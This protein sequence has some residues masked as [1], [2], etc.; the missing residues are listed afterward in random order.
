MTST[1]APTHEELVRRAAALRPLLEKHAA[2]SDENRRL[3]EE[4]VEALADA[5][6][7][8]MRVPAR[9]G[10]YESTART[11]VDVGAEL[12]RG[13][14]AVGWT[15]AIWTI[16]L[17]MAGLFPD[18]VQDEVFATP[19]VRVCGTLSPTAT[20]T[21]AKGGF[22]VDG[23]WSFVSGALHSHW[24]EILAMAPTPDGG[25]QPVM[26]LVP[27]SELEIVDDWH[28]GGLRGT[29]S[30][31]T[32][33]D[34][35]FVPQERVLPMGDV[36]QGK[37][38]SK[39]NADSPM[40]RAPLAATAGASTVGPALGMARAA[41]DVFVKRMPGRP[42]TS[43]GYQDQREAPVT[44]LQ[45]AEAAVRIDEA[46][47]HGYRLADQLDA[48]GV[49]GEPWTIA[50]R[51]RGR[52][53]VAALCRLAKESVDLLSLASG[54]SSAYESVPMQRITRNIQVMNLHALIYPPNAFELYGRVLSGLEPNTYFI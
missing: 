41:L 31:T 49:T 13:D 50:D 16:P 32:V 46:E 20:A 53:D 3:H 43:T 5:G 6:V 24:Q 22:V 26:A 33:A 4:V 12:G 44:H 54:G 29:G 10:G 36:L 40:F 34:S 45:L 11:L 52:A 38:A 8:R 51:A 9:Y 2:W 39:A 37:Y 28:T 1:D 17:W 25:Q 18:E 42:I 7:F 15:A 48:R 21:P 27:M 30:V 14:G 23:R 47:F 19:D 35:V